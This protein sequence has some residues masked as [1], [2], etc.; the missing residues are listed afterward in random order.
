MRTP[1][2]KKKGGEVSDFLLLLEGRRGE[3]NS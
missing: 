2:L 1:L 3:G